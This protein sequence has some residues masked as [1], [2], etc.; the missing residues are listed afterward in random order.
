MTGFL[1]RLNH[2]AVAAPMSCPMTVAMAAPR[3]PLSD[4]LTFLIASYMICKTYREL[5]TKGEV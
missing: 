3:M 4:I 1:T 5:S 2:S